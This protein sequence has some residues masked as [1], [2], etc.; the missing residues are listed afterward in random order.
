M[1]G[2]YAHTREKQHKI[3][4]AERRPSTEKTRLFDDGEGRLSNYPS[5]CKEPAAIK[6]PH[7]LSRPQTLCGNPNLTEVHAPGYPNPKTLP[8]NIRII[9]GPQNQILKPYNA[10]PIIERCNDNHNN[11]FNECVGGVLTSGRVTTDYFFSHLPKLRP[12]THDLRMEVGKTGSFNVGIKSQRM[13]HNNMYRKNR[14]GTYYANK[15]QP[16]GNQSQFTYGFPYAVPLAQDKN[17]ATKGS[18]HGIPVRPNTGS[19]GLKDKIAEL[20]QTGKKSM[21]SPP[22]TAQVK[23]RI[24]EGSKE[25]RMRIST[26]QTNSEKRPD[27]RYNRATL[28]AGLSNG[29]D[30]S[31]DYRVPVI[32]MNLHENMQEQPVMPNCWKE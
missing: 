6:E 18:S 8:K 11:Q 25:R 14:W 24:S 28:C 21:Y 4:Q 30:K 26:P 2:H 9:F 10:V 7:L 1:E 16:I 22:Q 23:S 29:R 20:K 13:Q 27:S 19:K 32:P 31:P 17:A 15:N 5:F 3:Y 12:E